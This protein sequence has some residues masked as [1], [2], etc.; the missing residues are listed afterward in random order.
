MKLEKAE[1]KGGVREADQTAPA[2]VGDSSS[3]GFP[4][5]A[6]AGGP[7]PQLKGAGF[8]GR[9]GGLAGPGTR[10]SL[11]GQVGG[12]QLSVQ[13]GLTAGAQG[14]GS[15]LLLVYPGALDP[16]FPRGVNA[17]SSSL[18]ISNELQPSRSRCP[19]P[20]SST[21]WDASAQWRR[22]VRKTAVLGS[23]G[24]IPGKPVPPAARDFLLGVQRAA[25]T[26]VPPASPGVGPLPAVEPSSLRAF[27][28]VTAE[29]AVS[30]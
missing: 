30:L 27:D 7:G 23:S 8:P 14:P 28:Q 5:G 16:K 11:P 12:S 22:G 20:L 15:R 4:R 24:H 9:E 13:T 17:H 1:P 29:P 25:K 18:F 2:P 21:L 19:W 10:E 3:L 6:H 26:S